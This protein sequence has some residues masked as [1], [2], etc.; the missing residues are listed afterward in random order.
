MSL[1]A[2]FE[3]HPTE[4]SQPYVIAEAGVNHEGSM[5]TARRLIEEAAGAGADAIKFQTYRAE[6]L[7]SRDSPAYWDTTKEPTSSQYELFKRHDTFW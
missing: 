4:L 5:D 7:A 6:T 2:L 1:T 3:R